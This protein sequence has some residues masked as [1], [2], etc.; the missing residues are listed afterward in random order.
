MSSNCAPDFIK[1]VKNLMQK[2]ESLYQQLLCDPE[3][4]DNFVCLQMLICT[5]LYYLLNIFYVPLI[6]SFDVSFYISI[7]M[8]PY[9]FHMLFLYFMLFLFNFNC[10]MLFFFRGAHS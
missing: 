8:M 4:V 5:V 2:E 7:F 6:L 9:L 1:E 3:K 10:P